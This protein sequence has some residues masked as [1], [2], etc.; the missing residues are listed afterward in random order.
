[1]YTEP[2]SLLCGCEYR[3]NVNPEIISNQYFVSV[4]L[5][6]STMQAVCYSPEEVQSRLDYLWK[7]LYLEHKCPQTQLQAI[8]NQIKAS[9]GIHPRAMN[10]PVSA[11]GGGEW[12][13]DGVRMV[14]PDFTD[15]R[16]GYDPNIGQ[17]ELSR[18]YRLDTIFC[19][20]YD[21]HPA[22]D[23]RSWR[24]AY[25]ETGNDWALT[26]MR[27]YW[28]PGADDYLNKPEVPEQRQRPSFVPK[29]HYALF[30]GLWGALSQLVWFDRGNGALLISLAALVAVCVVWVGVIIR[31]IGEVKLCPG[32]DG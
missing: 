10:G 13:E 14:P 4:R 29:P 8:E 30:L 21:M 17:P 16:G 3:S 28:K 18:E 19:D 5:G 6:S 12:A 32:G 1:M 31:R 25:E 22:P 23:Y 20:L 27:H 15:R 9:Y 11:G 7:R 24:T 26:R 2:A